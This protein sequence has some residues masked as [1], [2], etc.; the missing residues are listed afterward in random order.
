ME[1]EVWLLEV[2]IIFLP[3][4]VVPR[5]SLKWESSE[6]KVAPHNEKETAVRGRSISGCQGGWQYPSS[7]SSRPPTCSGSKYL[8]Y[9]SPFPTLRPLFALPL[10]L[11]VLV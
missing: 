3:N 8:S 4:A 6:V 2:F 9:P 10:F 5:M 11:P 7:G 1:G